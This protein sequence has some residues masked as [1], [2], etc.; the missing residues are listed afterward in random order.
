MTAA[1]CVLHRPA[2]RSTLI[3]VASRVVAWRDRFVLAYA[4]SSASTH[5]LLLTVALMVLS[6]ALVSICCVSAWTRVVCG[7]IRSWQSWARGSSLR[8]R[9]GA[10]LLVQHNRRVARGCLRALAAYRDLRKKKDAM[11]AVALVHFQ[12]RKWMQW[13]RYVAMC[14]AKRQVPFSCFGVRV[15]AKADVLVTA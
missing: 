10:L 4:V 6:S 13:R 12:W 14:K 3:T 2:S 15:V 9:S 11:S 7:A 5:F 1:Y 8:R